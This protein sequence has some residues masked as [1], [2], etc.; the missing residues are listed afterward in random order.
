MG[1]SPEDDSIEDR[2]ESIETEMS[3]IEFE[4]IEARIDVI[5]TEQ[6]QLRADLDTVFESVRAQG[7]EIPQ[8]DSIQELHTRL[9]G[10]EENVSALRRS[11]E[12][13]VDQRE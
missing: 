5:E 13:I 2:V 1:E 12:E 11:L 9:S 4:K 8:I 10:L 7:D 6:E 3:D